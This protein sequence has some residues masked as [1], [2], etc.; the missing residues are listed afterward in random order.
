MEIQPISNFSLATPL[1][2]GAKHGEHGEQ[3]PD[4]EQLGEQGEYDG[5]LLAK[6]FDELELLDLDLDRDNDLELE[7]DLDKDLDVVDL[8]LDDL[9]LELFMCLPP[10]PGIKLQL[11][12]YIK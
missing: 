10:S 11:N 9:D 5:V 12:K 6:V 7:L 1:P 4:G 2:V 8:D 3:D